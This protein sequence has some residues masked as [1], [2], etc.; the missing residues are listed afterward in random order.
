MSMTTWETICRDCHKILHSGFWAQEQ[1]F[2]EIYQESNYSQNEIIRHTRDLR[3]RGKTDEEIKE[4]LGL[5]SPMPWE[6]DLDYLG[7]LFGFIS[8]R[9]FKR[10][11]KPLLS[12]EEQKE[13][14]EGR[15][16]W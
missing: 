12:E 6:E 13:R 7:K 2:L 8:S 4:F 9:A 16:N 14:L 11:Q 15:A 3:A 10:M 5:K 1:D